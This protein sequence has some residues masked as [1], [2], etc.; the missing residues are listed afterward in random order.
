M[1]GRIRLTAV[2]DIWLQTEGG[3]HPFEEVGH[4]VRDKDIL[5]GNLETALSETGERAEKHH[6]IATSPDA[7][8]YLADAGFDILSVA[9]N[10]AG[11]LG[12]EGFRN[13]LDALTS[14]GI[15]PVGDRREPAII[16]R[17]GV[18]VGFIG[19]ATGRSPRGVSIN[20]LVEEDIVRDIAS[21]AGECDHIAVSLHWGV[22]MAP[23]PSP[24]QIDLARRLVDAGATLIL[25]HHAHTIQA[26][27]RYH[28]GLIA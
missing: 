21:L 26:I 22:E 11:D 2:G 15:L 23:Y 13:T 18:S 7:A 20:R 17:N 24:A 3:R 8:R 25:G 5:F 28:G 1:R 9:N 10:H 16:E 4:L 19:Y 6:V 14:R 27:E 12:A